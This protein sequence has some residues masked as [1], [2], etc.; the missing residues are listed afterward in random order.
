MKKI[1]A[2]A[3]LAIV[4]F[5]ACNENKSEDTSSSETKSVDVSFEEKQVQQ[6]LNRQDYTTALVNINYILA[7]DSTRKGL[8]DTLFSIYGQAQN[9]F[10]IADIG[11][12]ILKDR[13]DDLSI[14]EPTAQAF[15]YLEEFKLASEIQERMFKITN[16]PQIKLMLGQTYVYM[17]DYPKAKECYNWVIE[18]PNISDTIRYEMP[19]SDNPK[20]TQKI[21]VKAIAHSTLAQLLYQEG[22]KKAALAELEKATKIEPYFDGAL[23]M[24]YELKYGQR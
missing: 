8:R 19:M 1:F 22:Q 15:L 11:P 4:V 3:L 10:A 12:E 16:D 17:Q 23:K 13:P 14:L 21:K 18:N 2:S 20:K 7:K 5:S 24:I 6:A 9:I